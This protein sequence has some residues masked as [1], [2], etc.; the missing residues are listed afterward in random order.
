MNKL[1]VFVSLMPGYT[2]ALS[3]LKLRVNKPEFFLKNSV[4]LKTL[5][6]KI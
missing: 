5:Y 3:N 6:P 2:G 1:P 4:F